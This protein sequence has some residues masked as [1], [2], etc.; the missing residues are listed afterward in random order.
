MGVGCSGEA[1]GGRQ[2]RT[3]G[4]CGTRESAGLAIGWTI[5]QLDGCGRLLYN[6]EQ[7]VYEGSGFCM[8]MNLFV[9]KV[10]DGMIFSVDWRE[11][12]EMLGEEKGRG[13]VCSLH[14]NADVFPPVALETAGFS[15]EEIG[16]IIAESGVRWM[17]EAYEQD[18]PPCPISTRCFSA[19]EPK[20]GQWMRIP[21]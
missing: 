3:S 1:F 14:P 9:Q 10:A 17:K 21:E 13:H 2:G 15:E 6:R 19:V 5:L 7:M 4:C 12:C 11:I 20:A 8:G 16:T 18:D